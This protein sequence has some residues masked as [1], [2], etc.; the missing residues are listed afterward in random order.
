[1]KTGIATMAL[2]SAAMLAGCQTGAAKKGLS[3]GA[4]NTAAAEGLCVTLELTKRDFVVGEKMNVTITARNLTS[5]PLTIKA[6]SET[7]YFVKVWHNIG[8]GWEVVKQYPQSEMLIMTAWR[9]A[10]K[11]ERKFNVSVSVEPDWPTGELLRLTAE[12][13]GRPKPVPGVT[14][15]VAPLPE[16]K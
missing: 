16:P 11:A 9:L 14:I 1:M 3:P 15:T 2:L 7:P 8:V 6:A 10:A 12:L 5:Q 13:N 4:T